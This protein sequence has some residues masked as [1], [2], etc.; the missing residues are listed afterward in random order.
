M[1]RNQQRLDELM[2]CNP[3][4]LP[5]DVCRCHDDGCPER[6]E[7]KRYLQRNNGGVHVVHAA[8]LREGTGKCARKLEISYPAK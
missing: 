2:A 6:E 8:T 7:C 1:T 3:P 4:K 5:D